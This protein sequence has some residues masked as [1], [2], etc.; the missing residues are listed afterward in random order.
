LRRPQKAI[1]CLTRAQVAA[2]FACPK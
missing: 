2:L 1:N